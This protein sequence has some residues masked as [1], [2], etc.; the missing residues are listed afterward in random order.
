MGQ[1][2]VHFMSGADRAP[3]RAVRDDRLALEQLALATRNLKP[4]PYLM[5]LFGLV[6][7]TIFSRWIALPVLV[8]WFAALTL[9]HVPLAIVSY[10]FSSRERSPAELPKWT[11]LITGAYALSTLVWS[12]QVIFLWAPQNDF[13]HLLI[14]L[15]LAGYLSG[16]SPFAS[17]CIPL[18]ISIFAIAGTALVAA[19]LREGGGIYSSLAVITL[20]YA[21]YTMYM[22]HQMYVTARNM[23][24]LRND[25]TDLI[26]ALGT[27]KADSDRARY[28]AESASRSK[29]QFLANMSHELRTPLNAILGFSEIIASRALGHNAEKYFEY[30]EHIN[31]SGNHLLALINDILD[32]AKIEAGAFTL[33]ETDVDV[34]RLLADEVEI[35]QQ[36]A[37]TKGST[38]VSEISDKLPLVLADERAIRQ[39]V[40]NLL[41]NAVKFTPE[42]GRITVFAEASAGAALAFGVADTG[43]GIAKDDQ[44][45]IFENFGQGRHDVA[46]EDKG[47]GLGLPI[48]KGLVEA[49]GGNLSLESSVGSGTRVTVFLPTHRARRSARAA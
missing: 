28:R 3:E 17:P 2:A 44:T 43:V 48:V 38:I 31:R 12:T 32:L 10:R 6:V 7:C 34:A 24:L 40:L 20:F 16:Q 4:H 14:V 26:V 29:S 21:I 8:S 23:L 42:G 5:P 30:A 9:G 37:E 25:K 35:V 45:R 1:E 47:T 41:S 15:F 27:A 18:S 11:V 46:I 36:R 33:R 22:A 13:N 49:H 39:I 19:P